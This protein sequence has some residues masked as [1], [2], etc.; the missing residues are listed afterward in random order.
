M[1]GYFIFYALIGAISASLDMTV[2]GLI[3]LVV[4]AA[5]FGIHWLLL[6]LIEFGFGYLI[7]KATRS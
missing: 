3:V 4:M 5:I 7:G 1:I 6:D 2:V